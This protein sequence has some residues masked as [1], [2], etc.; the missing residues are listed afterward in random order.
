MRPAARPAR[1][2]RWQVSLA[3][4][5]VL[6]ATA[7]ARPLMLPDEGRY[8]GVAWEMLRSGDWWTPTLDGLPFFHK[9]PLFYWI[10]AAAMSMFG[11]HEWTARAASMLGA[12]TGATAVYLFAWRWGSPRLA[13]LAVVALLAQ[14]LFFLGGQFAN[15]DMLVAGCISAT[16]LLAAH[17]ALQ[18]QAGRPHRH[19]LA[20]AYV[21]AALGVLAKG[22]IGIVLP[23]LVI[24]V[25]LLALRRWRTL[26]ALWWW[27]GL[28]L[29]LAIAA[30]WFLVMQA[31]FPDFLNYF[32]VVQHF[33][34]FSGSGFN[35]VQAW[36]FYPAV[37]L[38]CHGLWLPWLL[39]IF[40]PTQLTAAR[41]DPV[42]LLMWVW[43]AVVLVFFSLPKSKL[44]GYVLPAVPPLVYLLADSFAVQTAAVEGVDGAHGPRRW[45]S[46]AVAL[47]AIGALAVVAWLA[48]HP[49]KSTRQLALVLKDRHQP[50]EPLF[51]LGNYDYDVP[52]Y[53]GLREPV[54]IVDAWDDPALA[55]SDNWRKEIAD[56]AGFAPARAS[57]SLLLPAQL[58]A[59]LCDAP[60]S[61]VIGPADQ[62]DAWPALAGAEQVY[63]GEGRVLWRVDR[64][65]A[66]QAGGPGCAGRPDAG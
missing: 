48:L 35:N 39:R 42:R 30:P 29:M 1:G 65:H 10:T 54:A 37:L 18:Q 25:W 12:W 11:M 32:F 27:P 56:A 16:V 63:R 61:W 57:A 26:L 66:G 50:T 43:F 60:L 52:F 38:L 19:A 34:R 24:V 28:L 49:V 14:P 2:E 7:W 46:G 23:G 62:A 3:I 44:V 36:W 53:A 4:L 33:Q 47:S 5:L 6:A 58:P 22:L 55:Q 21:F 13:R 45:W 20:G 40:A 51:M 8:A 59:A 17:G 15:L 64:R 31:R 9:P 41:R